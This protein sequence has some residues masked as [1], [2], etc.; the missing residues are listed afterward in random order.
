M[1]PKTIILVPSAIAFGL[2]PRM[3]LV[4]LPAGDSH[5]DTMAGSVL[6]IRVRVCNVAYET[7]L[8]IPG[9]SCLEP[10]T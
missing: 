8:G 9:K 10:A 3:R 4:W 7:Y 1:V 2:L 6:Q 5:L